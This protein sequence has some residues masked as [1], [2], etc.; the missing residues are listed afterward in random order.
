MTHVLYRFYSATGQLL[1]VGITMNPPERFKGHRDQKDWWDRVSGITVETYSSRE[2]LQRA[3]RR[4]IQVEHPQYNIIHNRSDKLRALPRSSSERVAATNCT[5]KN[6]NGMATH[7]HSKWADLPGWQALTQAMNRV[8]LEARLAGIRGN[9]DVAAEVMSNLAR[10]V[11]YMDRCPTCG[12]FQDDLTP[13]VVA[14]HKGRCLQ[15]LDVRPLSVRK[16]A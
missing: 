1:Y 2:E 14:P 5:K 16:R 10:S 13:A 9:Q 7:D 11:A 6:P 3:E 4:A 15:Q 12:P 8:V